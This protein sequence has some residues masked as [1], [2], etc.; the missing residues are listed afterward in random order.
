[1][2]AGWAAPHTGLMQLG[3]MM[4]RARA[5]AHSSPSSAA[6]P[7]SEPARLS[8]SDSG[9]DLAEKADTAM[10]DDDDDPEYRINAAEQLAELHS[11]PS[12]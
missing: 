4:K 12:V 5:S 9:T 6:T 11:R 7:S 1:M 2:V 3:Q 8:V 10:Y